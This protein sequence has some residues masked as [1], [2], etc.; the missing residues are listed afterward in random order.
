MLPVSPDNDRPSRRLSKAEKS[1]ITLSDKLKEILVGL[2][3]GG[4]TCQKQ[5]LQRNPTFKFTQGMRHKEYLFHLFELFQN[6][7]SKAPK[8]CNILP[9]KKT[10]KFY[11]YIVFYTYSLPCLVPLYELFFVDGNPVPK[12]VPTN[13]DKLLTS[14]GLC[15]WICEGGSFCKKDRSIILS[16]QDFSLQEVELLVKVLTDKFNLKCSINKNGKAFGILISTKSIPVIQSLLKEIMPP[17]M[18][19]KI[20]L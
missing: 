15:Y 5:K 8:K 13:I 14:L 18:L 9:D 4:L 16:T 10:G 7:C 3:L 12:V 11:T 2:I 17:M 20:G 6:Y 19:H 1:R